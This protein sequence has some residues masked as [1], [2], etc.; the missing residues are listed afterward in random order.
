MINSLNFKRLLWSLL[1]VSGTLTGPGRKS[2]WDMILI[3]K[4]LLSNEE[5]LLTELYKTYSWVLWGLR[6]ES[7][8]KTAS[9]RW[10]LKNALLVFRQ[11]VRKGFTE[12]FGQERSLEISPG[13]Q[14]AE[15][16]GPRKWL[17]GQRTSGAESMKEGKGLYWNDSHSLHGEWLSILPICTTLLE[18]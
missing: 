9:S 16:S 15:P 8:C 3:L 1:Y 18:V 14:R 10:V 5:A 12:A 7:L 4:E 11:K 13:R 2:K 6:K 17:T